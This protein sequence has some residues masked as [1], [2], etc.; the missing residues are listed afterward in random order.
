MA[1]KSQFGGT[2][3]GMRNLNDGID[4]TTKVYPSDVIPDKKIIEQQRQRGVFRPNNFLNDQYL[5]NQLGI[6]QQAPLPPNI[7]LENNED[8]EDD[9][10]DQDELEVELTPEEFQYAVKMTDVSI[11]QLT[12]Q[13]IINLR[14]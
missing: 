13:H 12:K 5:I 11:R 4:I 2:G 6:G 8:L 7:Q 3:N 14:K 9:G 10:D 1:K